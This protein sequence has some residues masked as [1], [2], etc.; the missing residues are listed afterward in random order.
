LLVAGCAVGLAGCGSSSHFANIHRPPT[1]INLT[2]YVNNQRVSVSPSRVGAGP[3]NFFVTNQAAAS[4]TVTIGSDQ[5][6]TGPINPGSS[7]QVQV[8]LGPGTYQVRAGG[9]ITPATLHIGA[10]RPSA[11]NTLLAP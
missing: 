5:N 4:E 9:G 6:T 11:D 7:A 1:P 3:V 2:V 8:D 10:P